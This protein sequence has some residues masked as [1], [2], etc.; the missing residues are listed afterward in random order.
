[1]HVF[2]LVAVYEFEHIIGLAFDRG[3]ER[4]AR[5]RIIGAVEDEIVGEFRRCDG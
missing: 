4:I 2:R 1:M 5:E 3:E